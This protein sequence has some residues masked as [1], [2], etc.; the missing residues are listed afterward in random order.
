MIYPVNKKQK[1]EFS[2]RD[3]LCHCGPVTASLILEYDTEADIGGD[4]FTSN[5]LKETDE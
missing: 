5:I 3:A 4:S 1:L 2:E